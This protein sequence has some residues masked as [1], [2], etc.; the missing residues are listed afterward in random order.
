MTASAY[1]L[2]FDA[3][4]NPMQLKKVGNWVFTFAQNTSA[5]DLEPIRLAITHVIPRQ[6][7]G[8]LQLRRMMIEQHQQVTLW[9]IVILECFDSEQQQEVLLQAHQATAQQMIQ[10]VLQEFSKYDVHV[11]LLDGGTV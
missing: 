2:K 6:S 3:F 9:H 1:L 8:S 10:R 7:D 5:N 4:D 11:E